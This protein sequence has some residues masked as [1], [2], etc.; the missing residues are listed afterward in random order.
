M[1]LVKKEVKYLNKDFGQ[2]RDKLVNFAKVY[3]PD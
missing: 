3:F 1:A 2:F